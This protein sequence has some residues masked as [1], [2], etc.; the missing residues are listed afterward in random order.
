MVLYKSRE[1]PDKMKSQASSAK[2]L[3]FSAHSSC[4]NNAQEYVSCCHDHQEHHVGT[5]SILSHCRNLNAFAFHIDIFYRSFSFS[6]RSFPFFFCLLLSFFFPSLFSFSCISPDRPSLNFLPLPKHG[7]IISSCCCQLYSP[8][9]LCR[10]HK[11][12]IR[13][14]VWQYC[15][16]FQEKKGNTQL[17]LFPNL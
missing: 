5:S 13:F 17:P 12:H 3:R 16:S 14:E 15:I 2:T 4:K 6:F 9:F 11:W 10:R 8:K 1:R 7:K